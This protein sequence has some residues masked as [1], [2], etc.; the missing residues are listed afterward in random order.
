MNSGLKSVCEK[1]DSIASQYLEEAD[2]LTALKRELGNEFAKGFLD[3]GHAKYTMGASKLSRYSYDERMKSLFEVNINAS[4]KEE[5]TVY[6]ISNVVFNDEERE[7]DTEYDEKQISEEMDKLSLRQRA[8]N[9]TD[10]DAHCSNPKE[11]DG[12]N[13]D[14]I[15]EKDP[16]TKPLTK[17][18]KKKKVIDRD[19]LH[20]FGLLVSPSLRT[21]QQHFKSVISRCIQQANHEHKLAKL[22]TQYLVLRQEKLEII[23][24]IERSAKAL[25]TDGAQVDDREHDGEIHDELEDSEII[26]DQVVPQ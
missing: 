22:E 21:S 1:L 12:G 20:W 13:T 10:N 4:H 24:E 11:S 18:T 14:Q 15:T 26:E 25:K 7:K 2:A 23:Q 5:D 17:S 8:K 6:S 3:L 19:P 9:D 16:S